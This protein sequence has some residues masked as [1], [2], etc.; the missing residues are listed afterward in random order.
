MLTTLEG[1]GQ[2][3]FQVAVA[4]PAQGPLAEA[5][6]ARGIEVE[7]FA[8]WDQAGTRRPQ[9]ALRSELAAMLARRRPDLVHANSLA[10]GRLSG[11]V[12][13]E[14]ETP[15][16]SHLRD[17]LKLSTRAVADLNQ[18]TRI[19]AVSQ[20]VRDFHAAQGLA[21]ARLRVLYNGVDLARFHPRPA[22]G[23]LHRELGLSHE[24]RL[25][26]AIGQIGLRKGLD[27]FAQA[28]SRIARK[29]PD[30][31]FLFV[32]ERHSEKAESRAFEAELHRA[33]GGL[34]RRFHFLGR[35]DDV[36]Q[37]LNELTLLVHPAR[38][39]PLGRVLLEAAASGVAVVATDV[40]GT[41]EIFPLE[42]HS[43]RLVAPGDAAALAA[44]VIDLLG[45]DVSRARIAT[46][47][48]RRAEEAFDAQQAAASLVLHYRQVLGQL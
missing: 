2:A 17:I 25:L 6:R 9:G 29:M 39:E 36:P 45:D 28:A 1:I 24:A 21:P 22:T 10:M 15:S 30:A 18:H 11:P 35:R 14:S 3:D 46:E 31:H 32:G 20:A 41:R 13:A 27:V 44:A 7:P 47:A 33:A 4:A 19:L 16:I 26:G 42:S 5:L 48:R 40:G 8:A 38:Q 43:A 23:F 34:P 12:V 37:L